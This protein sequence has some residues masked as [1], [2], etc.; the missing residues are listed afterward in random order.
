[1]GVTR[2]RG[3]VRM[4]CSIP[5]TVALVTEAAAEAPVPV[6]RPVLVAVEALLELLEV[7]ALA[8][9]VVVAPIAIIQRIA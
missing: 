5:A 1:M 2:S 8:A 9:A 3:Y 6:A 7:A 4:P